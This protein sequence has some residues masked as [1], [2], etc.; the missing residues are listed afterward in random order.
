MPELPEVETARRILE[1]ELVGRRLPTADLRLPKL[2]RFSDPPTLEPLLGRVVTGVRRRA[3][4]L[5]LD[6]SEGLSLVAHLKMTGQIIVERDGERW[7]AGHPV[8]DPDGALPHKATHLILGFE[9]GVTLYLSDVRQF[10]WLRLM[11]SAGVEPFLA[12]LRLGPDAVG[13]GEI[14]VAALAAKLARRAIPIKAALLDQAVI[15]GIGNIYVDEALHEAGIHPLTPAS[16]L[17]SPDVERLAAAVVWALEAGIAQGGAK[18]RH[19]R[20]YPVDGFPRVHARQ[21]EACVRC[22]GEIVKI[23]VRGRGTY[24]CPTCQ[25][26]TTAGSPTP[27]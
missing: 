6:W 1:R 9:G 14:D 11:D 22:S 15:A 26:Q 20:A 3:K 4:V 13:A 7:M 16:A 25:P 10:G 21:G 27:A 17:T 8:P 2:L 12:T 18:I 5:I 19:G 23:A 24:L